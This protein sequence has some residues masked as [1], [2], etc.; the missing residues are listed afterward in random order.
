[1]HHK[2]LSYCKSW[3]WF[4]STH[5]FWSYIK[6]AHRAVM[7]N[8]RSATII[9]WRLNLLMKGLTRTR[10][11]MIKYTSIVVKVA[12]YRVWDLSFNHIFACRWCLAMVSQT[13]PASTFIGGISM[14]SWWPWSK[15]SMSDP[16]VWKATGRKCWSTTC[17]TSIFWG[18]ELQKL[19]KIKRKKKWDRKPNSLLRSIHP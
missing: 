12:W 10:T 8:F 3:R 19:N 13:R 11:E 17:K 18:C 14:L 16:A 9:C 4:S 5:W 2:S 6:K 15:A 7:H 1:M